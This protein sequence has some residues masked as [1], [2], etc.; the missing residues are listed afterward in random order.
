MQYYTDIKPNN[1]NE[2][3]NGLNHI[4]TGPNGMIYA[5]VKLMSLS[6]KDGL[7][8]Y[9][10]RLY[11]NAGNDRYLYLN[12]KTRVYNKSITQIKLQVYNPV[13]LRYDD[14]NTDERWYAQLQITPY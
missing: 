9:G 10:Y 3:R 8:S 11:F 7:L 6:N 2:I 12:S 13:H 4:L 1:E 5:E 14:V